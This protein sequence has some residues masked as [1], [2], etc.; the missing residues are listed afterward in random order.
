MAAIDGGGMRLIWWYS[1]VG[2]CLDQQ[3]AGVA[4][5]FLWR[6][7]SVGSGGVGRWPAL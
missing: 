1:S 2:S 5:L 6:S 7:V 4:V 3:D